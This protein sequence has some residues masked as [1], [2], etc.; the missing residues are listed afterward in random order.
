MRYGDSAAMVDE[1]RIGS[2]IQNGMSA[3]HGRRAM[4]QIKAKRGR[5]VVPVEPRRSRPI[6]ERERGTDVRHGAETV[7]RTFGDAPATTTVSWGGSGVPQVGHIYLFFWGEQWRSNPLPSP[8]AEDVFADIV[9]ILNSP[10]LTK[11]KQYFVRQNLGITAA[12]MVSGGVGPNNGFSDS[13]V[14]QFVANQIDIY[15]VGF[16]NEAVYIVMMPPGIK[17]HDSSVTGSHSAVYETVGAQDA[18][19][20][21]VEYDTTGG[22]TR[23][24]IS[25]TFSHELA[26]MLTD[27]EGDSLQVDP[28]DDSNW[29]EICDI[30][31]STARVSG[32]SVSSYWSDED[33]ACVVPIDVPVKNRQIDCINKGIPMTN[34]P[35]AVRVAHLDP[36]IAIWAVG[37]VSLE[38]RQRFSRTQ[39]DVIKDIQQGMNY[40]VVGKDGSRAKVI[41]RIVFPPWNAQGVVCIATTPDRSIED[42][43]LSLPECV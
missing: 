10:Y 18:H 8:S 19:V 29:N 17:P 31:F 9:K 39:K 1:L 21:W 12:Y 24:N 32:V 40:F 11:L 23:D 3:H 25:Q 35:A 37:G 33:K 4:R 7:V 14:Q 2:R 16:S 13:D 26:E 27:P 15:N 34:D 43:L 28:R 36:H 6:A 5:G 42:N 30:C 41:V 20:A 22:T 38:T